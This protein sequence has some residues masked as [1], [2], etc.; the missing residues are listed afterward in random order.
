MIK[1]SQFNPNMHLIYTIIIIHQLSWESMLPYSR[2]HTKTTQEAA[3][4]IEPHDPHAH[5]THTACTTVLAHEPTICTT[6]SRTDHDPPCCCCTAAM[7]A[8]HHGTPSSTRPQHTNHPVLIEQD[9]K[10]P[11]TRILDQRQRRLICVWL[12][13]DQWSLNL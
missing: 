5:G 10:Q 2:L 13:K 3:R 11:R 6:A 9:P 7:H 4:K 12:L 8:H 1:T